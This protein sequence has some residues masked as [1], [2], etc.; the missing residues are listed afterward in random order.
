MNLRDLRMRP[1][2]RGWRR[3]QNKILVNLSTKE[4]KQKRLVNSGKRKV[5]DLFVLKNGRLP[6]EI[7]Y[8]NK[9]KCNKDFNL[10]QY[11]LNLLHTS[12]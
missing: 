8:L 3:H 9:V 5:E 7:R 6:C 12:K 10:V 1:S 2:Y 11:S 4:E